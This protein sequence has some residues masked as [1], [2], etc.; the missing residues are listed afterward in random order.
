MN[1]QRFDAIAK[2][3]A[4]WS[5]RRRFLSGLAGAAAGGALLQPHA[6]IAQG[7]SQV[8]CGLSQ[9]I[10]CRQ[11]YPPDG[12]PANTA[13]LNTIQLASCETLKAGLPPT[14]VFN[15]DSSDVKNPRFF[16]FVSHVY[17]LL[18]QGSC[19]VNEQWSQD[20]LDLFV[21]DIVGQLGAVSTGLAD[22]FFA[23][24]KSEPPPDNVP[25]TTTSLPT[26]CTEA[27]LGPGIECLNNAQSRPEAHAC[28]V[29]FITCYVGTKDND[30]CLIK[31][32]EACHGDCCGGGCHP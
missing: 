27:C 16:G 6:G 10:T 19:A 13:E 4:S 20:R 26:T 17:R 7:A 1:S 5:S 22:A 32:H 14:D 24:P 18:E 15:P 30:G 3:L 25:E 29:K 31:F 21:S 12:E 8:E 2:S 11:P 9:P 23:T 28:Y